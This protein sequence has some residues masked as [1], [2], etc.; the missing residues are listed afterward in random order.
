MNVLE[1]FLKYVS[2]DTTSNPFGMNNPTSE[3]QRELANVLVKE[4]KDLNIEVYYDEVHCYVY[5]KLCGNSNLPYI[6]LFA[7]NI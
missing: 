4:L 3:N 7:V 1:R 6:L 2:I 5:G